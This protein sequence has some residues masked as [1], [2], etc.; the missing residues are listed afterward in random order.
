MQAFVSHDVP[1]KYVNAK[2]QFV[3]LLRQF[4]EYGGGNVSV[5]FVD[6]TPNSQAAL[7]A[8]QSGIEP[9]DDR[10]DL[11]GRMVEQQVYLGATISTSL[12]DVTIP[13]LT[14][15]SSIEYELSRSIATVDKK[16]RITLGILESDA[17]FGGPE[18]DGRR[19][20]WAYRTTLDE[21]KKQFKIKYIAQDEMASYVADE[22][23]K[24]DE[25][26]DSGSDTNVDSKEPKTP[27]DVLFVADPSSLDDPTM[28]ALVKYVE[29]GN[30]TIVLADPL[31]FFWT[32][33][34]PT[35]IGVLNAPRQ[36]RISSALPLQPDSHQFHAA[37]I[38][39]WIRP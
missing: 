25:A 16:Q 20:D 11:G 38:R 31:P 3:G 33:Q 37:E 2:K 1:R 7:E 4:S 34:N 36:P 8:E 23:D 39:W 30:P 24:T 26:A 17:H 35:Q 13:A 19:L 18:L 10:S 32:F 27:P 6:V 14:P 9:Q 28:D 15:D 5:R 21:L 22:S 29:A 12:G